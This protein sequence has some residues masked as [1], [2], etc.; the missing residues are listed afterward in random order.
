MKNKF[1]ESSRF[2]LA[3]N[4]TSFEESIEFYEAVFNAIA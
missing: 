4:T 1:K 2:H 3:L